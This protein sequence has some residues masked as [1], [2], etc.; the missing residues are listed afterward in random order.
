MNG[1]HTLLIALMSVSLLGC[2]KPATEEDRKA[3]T[4]LW[5]PDDGNG[6]ECLSPAV[7]PKI[8]MPTKFTK[9]P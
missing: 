1:T 9:A 3:L 4:G 2:D 5:I 6:N 7:T 8:P